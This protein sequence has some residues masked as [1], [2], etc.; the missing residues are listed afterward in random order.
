MSGP[1]TSSRT[2]CNETDRDSRYTSPW[3]GGPKGNETGYTYFFSRQDDIDRNT[4]SP[5]DNA[6]QGD[7]IHDPS[8]GVGVSFFEMRQK[9]LY[10]TVAV[11]LGS[12][13]VALLIR[14]V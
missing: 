11:V 5:D 12:V 4:T 10:T 9:S 8:E 13:V 1:P 2:I 7:L 6:P 3:P 14:L